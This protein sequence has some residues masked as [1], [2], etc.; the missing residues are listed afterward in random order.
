MAINS[1][2]DIYAAIEKLGKNANVYATEEIY[3]R[4]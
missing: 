4:N 2:T 3:K 1:D